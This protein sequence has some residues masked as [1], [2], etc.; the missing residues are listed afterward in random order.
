[1]PHVHQFAFD[2]ALRCQACIICGQSQGGRQVKIQYKLHSWG[3]IE[4][5][6]VD[7]SAK[8]LLIPTDWDFPSLAS[9]WGW[10]ACECGATD[11]T[12]DC[13]H[14]VA[15]KMIPEAW[16]FLQEHEGET[17]YDPGYFTIEE[18]YE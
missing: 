12:I 14:R 18:V 6:P 10:E 8:S 7:R 4:V 17:I 16:E 11:G 3:A 1:M 2:T 5:F 15:D 13:P 9:S